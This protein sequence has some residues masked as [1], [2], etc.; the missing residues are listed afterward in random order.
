M[1]DL[2]AAFDSAVRNISATSGRVYNL[3]GGPGNAVSLRSLLGVLEELLGKP[4]EVG[5]GDWRPG[6][7]RVYVSDIRKAESE[8]AW[9]P[10]IG[11]AEGVRRLLSWAQENRQLFE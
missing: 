10:R 11:A 9:A 2:I 5:Y 3:G 1:D 4:V 7:Q 8:L 6:D